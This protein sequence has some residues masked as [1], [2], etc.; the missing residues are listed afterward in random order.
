[1][2]NVGSQILNSDYNVIRNKVINILGTG[3]G[4][5]GYGQTIQSNLVATGNQVTSAQ[6]DS[7][8]LDIIN[9][10]VHQ[11]GASPI[12]SDVSSGQTIR[13][14]N[15]NPN[16][17]YGALA[18]LIIAN[19]FTVAD[20]QYVI[21]A[22]ITRTFTS[23][24]N[25][26]LSTTV[27]ITFSTPEE[28]RYFFNSGGKIRFRSTR[29]GGSATSQNSSWSNL[30]TGVGTIS[31]GADTQ[32]CNFY[33][34]TNTF[35]T[36]YALSANSPYAS[37]NFLIR[38]YSNV[39]NN[40]AGGATIL[41]F[42]VIWSDNYAY[43]GS[44]I[45]A[46]VDNVNGTLSLIVEEVR[47]SG[48]FLPTG[49]FS[50]TR[51]AYSATAIASSVTPTYNIYT[52]Q[53]AVNEGNSVAVVL[54]TSSVAN[55]T[56]LY[57]QATGV[58]NSSD[59]SAVLGTFTVL[60]NFGTFNLNVTADM[61]TEGTETFTV[62]VRTGSHSGPI[63]ATSPTITI[64]D[65]SQTASYSIIP[66][67]STVNEGN[68]V[69]FN[70][71]TTGLPNG[72]ILYWTTT[73]LSGTVLAGDFADGTLSGQVVISGNAGIIQ[74]TISSDITTE[75]TETF[76]IQLRTGSITGTIVATSS[77]VTIT[78]TST[79]PVAPPTYAIA[80]NLSTI[81]E[82]Q[83]VTFGI[84]TT[85]VTNGTNL[86]W[87]L[88]STTGVVNSG[89]FVGGTISGTVTINSSVA[90]IA[91]T[92]SLDSLTEGNEAFFIQ[93][94]TASLGGPVV[95]SSSTVTVIDTSTTPAPAPVT[96]TPT[97][98]FAPVS[99][100]IFE[101]QAAVFVVT[102]TN[103]GDGTTL[104]WSTSTISG[105]LTASDFTDNSLTG[106]VQVNSNTAV[107]T[108]TL[109]ADAAVEGSES[110]VLRVATSSGGVSQAQS[111]VVFVADTTPVPPAV[112]YSI[113]PSANTIN[114]GQ[115]VVFVVNTTSVSNGTVL[116]WD[117][118]GGQVSSS[119]FTDGVVSGQI[120]INNNVSSI[121]RSLVSDQNTEGS[122]SFRL[123]IRSSPSGTVLATSSFVSIND[124][125]Q[126][127]PA[128]VAS[129]SVL[130][131]VTTIDEGQSVAFTV[132]TTNVSVGTTLYWTL[133]NISGTLTTGDFSG[134]ATSGSMVV[135]LGTP[136]STDGYGSFDFDGSS[137]LNYTG[138]SE[139][140]TLD[141]DFTVE[142]WIKQSSRPKTYN[143]FFEL[144]SWNNPT[145][146][147]AA[148]DQVNDIF[149]GNSIALGSWSEFI[150]F[151][152]WTHVAVTRR[153]STVR[154]FVSGI[155]RR[156]YVGFNA[157]IN[158]QKYG[159]LL[160][161][162]RHNASSQEFTGKISNVRVIKGTAL[163]I[164]NFTVPS[165]P[166]TAD[167]GGRVFLGAHRN[168]LSIIPKQ[169]TVTYSTDN[170]FGT[171]PLG[172]NKATLVVSVTNDRL[173]EGD[174]QWR[175]QV[176]TNSAVGPVVATSNTITVRDTSKSVTYQL[177]TGTT[178]LT[179]SD[180]VAVPFT[181]TT[182]NVPN[183]TGLFWNIPFTGG[184]TAGD[185]VV[186]SGTVIINN[187]TATFNVYVKAD[188]LTEGTETFTVTLRTG[189]YFGDIVATS[190]ARTISDTS[191][192]PAE[193]IM[194]AVI[195][196][197]STSA[198][199]LLKD[200]TSFRANY[201]T[202]KFYLLMPGTD[203]AKL[204]VPSTFASD[205]R[206]FGPLLVARDGNNATK[207]TDWFSLID[208]N[209]IPT[210]TKIA[211]SI[212]DSGSMNA[213]TVAASK[214]LFTDKCALK[215][216]PIITVTMSGENWIAGFNR[217]F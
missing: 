22:G 73:S 97:Y 55:G 46:T 136:I 132:E 185:F 144:G 192:T 146:L 143:R 161:S 13:F 145:V 191:V 160:G 30:L 74:R 3:A 156:E 26:A 158:S 91:L 21:D 176:R 155:L 85:N 52:S 120:S 141:N 194:I 148:D 189:S 39:T 29:T 217:S 49:S 33:N 202:R 99:A 153:A 23:D 77:T 168:N 82:G 90:S 150:P 45:P 65:T 14:G 163:Y 169:G 121:T 95:A 107:I 126:A 11:N 12:I 75:G 10:I 59:M 41:Y 69:T 17:Q 183:S 66:A 157:I 98:S 19:K 134:G 198:T 80:P 166:I 114:E 60:N 212:D 151:N 110:F 83:T 5:S 174:E 186:G 170:P 117:T 47:A 173:T 28:A 62:T 96:Q 211:L 147:L 109:S 92:L 210:G 131:N 16:N 63:V 37:N 128:P 18:D 9:A 81:S 152:T 113:T 106:T 177:T 142:M 122:E 78:D 204:K 201:P 58:I 102:T 203:P 32:G 6:W 27:T 139:Q 115:S 56:T 38:A 127:P 43:S 88:Q 61:L 118:D 94:R 67:S 129:Y 103:V 206:A 57:W 68:I 31:F 199:T 182:T 53:T 209:S 213:S 8:K 165:T 179:E 2:S 76:N 215:G 50:I 149:L 138:D 86:Y 4:Q 181:V 79:T 51:P 135:E 89:D 40:S 24:W 164:S 87:T 108:R 1:M 197:T 140:F 111:N 71:S 64:A 205:S 15:T 116:Y 216:L 112:T 188:L 180:T 175:L 125:S 44:G 42:N 172:N 123:R 54:T 200:W 20:G 130:A 7:L 101:G 208:G 178:T 100:N 162:S 159:P 133:Q 48:A 171:A 72:T 34:L 187:N 93:L 35:Q 154:A 196:E 104:Y 195:D 70:I 193:P 184:I 214:K 207:A 137:Y 167:I 25:T 84:T 105:T 36:V 190:P 119:D 124:T